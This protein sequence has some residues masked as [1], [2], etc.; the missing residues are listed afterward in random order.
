MKGWPAQ[1]DTRPGVLGA[2]RQKEAENV[3]QTGGES[4]P[5]LYHTR[6]VPAGPDVLSTQVIQRNAR[7]QSHQQAPTNLVIPSAKK[8]NGASACCI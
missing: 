4:T 6:Y 5:P 7:E 2:S 3:M 8:L 1:P